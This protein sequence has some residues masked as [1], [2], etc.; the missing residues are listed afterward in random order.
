MNKNEKIAHCIHFHSTLV[1]SLEGANQP[2]KWLILCNYESWLCRLQVQTLP[3]LD[4]HLDVNRF[5]SPALYSKVYPARISVI[6]LS[7]RSYWTTSSNHGGG[8]TGPGHA[9][10]LVLCESFHSDVSL[11][12]CMMS[13]SSATYCLLSKPLLVWSRVVLDT[14]TRRPHSVTW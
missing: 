6:V 14:H 3:Y 10:N 13:L 8:K 4:L 9:G 7:H 12:S 11:S 2:Q 1:K 5:K